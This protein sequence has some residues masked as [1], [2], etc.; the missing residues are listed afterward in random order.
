[1]SCVE[2]MTDAD[3]NRQPRFVRR[4]GKGCE[5]RP[6]NATRL[7]GLWL[8]HQKGGRNPALFHSIPLTRTL[9]PYRR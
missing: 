9:E 7:W 5:S 1:M 2:N 6:H 4:S 3:T 8:R